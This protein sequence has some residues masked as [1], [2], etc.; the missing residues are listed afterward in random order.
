MAS[1][2]E[3]DSPQSTHVLMTTTT[4][5]TTTTPTNTTTSTDTSTAR[6]LLL[7]TNTSQEEGGIILAT[8]DDDD[9][10]EVPHDSSS[11]SQESIITAGAV[12]NLCSATLGAG[13]LALPHAMARAGV[14]PGLGLLV[15]AAMATTASIRL[16][17]Q[18]VATYRQPSYEQLTLTLFGP[19]AA[20]AVQA[21]IVLFCQGCAVAYLIAVADILQGANLL[22]RT[23]HH[24]DHDHDD[25][26]RSYTMCL[27]WLTVCLPL[28]LLRRMQTLQA[29]SAVGMASIGTLLFA[30]LIHLMEDVH[31]EYENN[32]HHHHYGNHTDDNSTN[33][34]LLMTSD[35]NYI[36]MNDFYYN[37]YDD[38]N[39]N[40][41]STT[42]DHHHDDDDDDDNVWWPLNG[43]YSVLQACPV[44]LFAFS[45]QVNVCAIF[46]ELPVLQ[47]AAATTTTTL[48][49]ENGNGNHND[50]NSPEEEEEEEEQ[51]VDEEANGERED[52]NN[53]E[54][55]TSTSLSFLYHP[56]KVPLMQRVAVR[57]VL[58][59][60][61]LYAAMAWTTVADF[62]PSQVQPN[63]LQNY[64]LRAGVMQVAAAGM[65]VA[66]CMA[67][68]LNIFPARVTCLTLFPAKPV[69]NNNNNNSGSTT[70]RRR[71][72]AGTTTGNPDL[73]EA[74]LQDYYDETGQEPGEEPDYGYEEHVP[75]AELD[76]DEDGNIRDDDEDNDA[77]PL[78]PPRPV[79]PYEP[80]ANDEGD[81]N[82]TN[83]DEME[84]EGF[85]NEYNDADMTFDWARHVVWTLILSGSAL[86]LA[87]VIPNIAVVF[88]VLGGTTSSLLGFCVPGLLGL[89]LERDALQKSWARYLISWCLL[90]GGIAV[91]ILTTVLT[92]QSITGHGRDH[93]PQ[94][95]H[96][97]SLT[98]YY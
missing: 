92:V 54:T 83:E 65:A 25:D 12:A 30:A 21:C 32:H 24:H 77:S 78:T 84:P 98:E 57:S 53:N 90:L 93:T 27:V 4:T 52:D 26:S 64:N 35:N 95:D 7:H 15:L 33:H 87:L 39:D 68:P 41:T 45:C 49:N 94:N 9:D 37:V 89:R 11:S 88:S 72:A 58:V 80:P 67:F 46:L 63:M 40:A 73:T 22:L 55:T 31:A 59:C 42:T 91:G 85:E 16:L 48:T 13:I 62:G 66:V 2:L 6:L 38:N 81:E 47:A 8:H 20:A 69:R 19:T 75:D 18:A 71:S 79:P 86:G 56:S 23:H 50:N 97:Q 36:M 43:T 17:V 10:D 34:T 61:V 82:Q 1:P 74:L 29:A 28:S 5:T 14:I 60:T 96:N 70:N 76:E 51:R 44:I 3:E